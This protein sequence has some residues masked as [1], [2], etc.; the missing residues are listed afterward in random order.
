MVVFLPVAIVDVRPSRRR[1]QLYSFGTV[2]F[3]AGIEVGPA[4]FQ[5]VAGTVDLFMLVI[6]WPCKNITF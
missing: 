4:A 5:A 3:S 1:L 6:D 2:G